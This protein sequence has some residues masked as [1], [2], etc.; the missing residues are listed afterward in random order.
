MS[1]GGR[2]APALGVVYDIRLSAWPK[3]LSR[4]ESIITSS[5]IFPAC[6]RIDPSDLGG[7]RRSNA[8]GV[9]NAMR[10]PEIFAFSDRVEQRK[11]KRDGVHVGRNG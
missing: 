4:T 8:E 2:I 6:R 7:R 10:S 3:M 1:R 5:A 11:P 9:M